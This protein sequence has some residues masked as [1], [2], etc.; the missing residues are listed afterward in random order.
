MPNT[1]KPGQM[2]VGQR[3]TYGAVGLIITL[4]MSSMTFVGHPAISIRVFTGMIALV[5]AIGTVLV[6]LGNSN[7]WVTRSH[8]RHQRSDS[9]SITTSALVAGIFIGLAALSAG[10]IYTLGITIIY[11][12]DDPSLNES[13]YLNVEL[14]LCAIMLS[15]VGLALLAWG[16]TGRKR[17]Q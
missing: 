5:A 17:P 10:F 15:C 4:V 8:R 16:R 11:R 13:H 3:V 1:L 9:G 7:W 12:S 6:I 14:A 2:P